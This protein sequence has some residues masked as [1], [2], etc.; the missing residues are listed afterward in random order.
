MEELGVGER[1]VHFVGTFNNEA[2]KDD[3]GDRDPPSVMPLTM[4]TNQFA[5]MIWFQFQ[6]LPPTTAA[7]DSQKTQKDFSLAIR[8]SIALVSSTFGGDYRRNFR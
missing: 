4:A 5:L 8:I 1:F 7:R 2:L 6:S 3:N